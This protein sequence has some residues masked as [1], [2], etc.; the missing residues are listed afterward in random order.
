MSANTVEILDI[1]AA[2]DAETELNEPDISEAISPELCT[3][4]VML[5]PDP[6]KVVAEIPLSTDRVSSDA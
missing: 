6:A 5:V 3:T 2:S 1:S 4:P